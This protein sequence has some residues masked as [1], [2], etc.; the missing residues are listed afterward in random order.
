MEGRFEY[1]GSDRYA[2]IGRRIMWC[3]FPI[4]GGTW[5][6]TI[7]V[8]VKSDAATAK[9]A[10]SK[11]YWR[12]SYRLTLGLLACVLLIGAVAILVAN[13]VVWLRPK[14]YA[15]PMSLSLAAALVAVAGVLL[16]MQW[17]F[18]EKQEE[19]SKFYLEKSLA[20]WD[21]A[22]EI[23]AESVTGI[24]MERRTKWI[25][26]ARILERSRQL[27]D[28]VTE[29]AHRDVLEIELTHQ[30]QRFHQFFE[31]PAPFYYGVNV[32]H[33][34]APLALDEAA[35]Q[36]TQAEGSTISTLRQIP[37]SAIV[38]IWRALQFPTD[39]W[40][41][42]ERDDKFLEGPILF[43]DSGL[44]DYIDHARAWHSVAG[45]LYPRETPADP[46]PGSV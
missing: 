9:K 38:T 4:G 35:R 27:G 25:A 46:T 8:V 44:R 15:D 3:S 2:L 10:V 1:A 18:S 6:M 24:A 17:K 33:V 21:K 39:Y 42:I 34:D 11:A 14:Q 12:K 20:G 28:R 19:R 23:L 40:D 22:R 16:S 32:L 29:S 43:L 45:Q 31:Q 26:A 41:V 5:Q 13:V 37:E 36:S 7:R 30:R